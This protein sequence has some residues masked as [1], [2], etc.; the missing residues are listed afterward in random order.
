MIGK[1]L[2]R[3]WHQNLPT[4]PWKLSKCSTP[5]KEY[6]HLSL[7]VGEFCTYPE[8]KHI[9]SE[10]PRIKGDQCYLSHWPLSLKL[11]FQVISRDYSVT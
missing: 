2:A 7:T 3:S 10:F 5:Q 9:S 6:L 8:G 4:S 1:V 11:N